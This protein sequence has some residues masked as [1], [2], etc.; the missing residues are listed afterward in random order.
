MSHHHHSSTDKE[1]IKEYKL[2]GLII[3]GYFELNSHVIK[4][5]KDRYST[6]RKLKLLKQYTPFNVRK[7]VC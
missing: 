5:S 3:D 7:Q 4:V 6:L 2:L 1:R